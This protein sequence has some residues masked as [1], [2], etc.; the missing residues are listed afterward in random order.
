MNAYD[1]A[2]TF[3]AAAMPRGSEKRRTLLR[4]VAPKGKHQNRQAGLVQPPPKMVSKILRWVEDNKEEVIAEQGQKLTRIPL[5]MSGWRYDR[6]AERFLEGEA[7]TYRRMI[8][9]IQD[10]PEDSPMRSMLPDILQTLEDGPQIRVVLRYNARVQAA[11]AWNPG[12]RQLDVEVNENTSTRTIHRVIRHE[13]QH[14]AQTLLKEALG[15]VE[16]GL[17]SKRIRT[18]Q[19]KQ[20]PSGGGAAHILD[21][22]EFYPR[23]T[24]AIE[25][26]RHT[27]RLWRPDGVVDPSVLRQAMRQNRFLRVLKQYAPG[28][29]RKAISEIVKALN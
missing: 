8:Q 12:M 11:G 17:P 1:K 7:G 5:D 25:E 26:I 15:G 3:L 29:Y 27:P 2:L 6:H 19:Y 20:D 21:D 23:L 10:S 24:D 18:P 4:M 16:A 14:M 13:A 9:H 22:Q 28:K